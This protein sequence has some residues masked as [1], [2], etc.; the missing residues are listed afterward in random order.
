MLGTLAVTERTSTLHPLVIASLVVAMLP[1]L[2][3]LGHDFWGSGED[4]KVTAAQVVDL[5]QKLEKTN[6]RLDNFTEQLNAVPKQTTIDALASNIAKEADQMH[7]DELQTT[8]L[9]GRVGAIE[10]RVNTL[11]QQTRFRNPK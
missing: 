3:D 2:V 7:D 8:R 9:D 4:Q 11:E 5:A 6:V 1:T 10:G